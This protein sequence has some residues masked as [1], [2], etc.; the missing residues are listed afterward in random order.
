VFLCPL[1][2]PTPVH[3]VGFHTPFNH[4][5]ITQCDW[6]VQRRPAPLREHVQQT[7]A[8]AKPV[9]TSSAAAADDDTGSHAIVQHGGRG[10]D[11]CLTFEEEMNDLIS[12][13]KQTFIAMPAKAAGSSLKQLTKLKLCIASKV[14]GG[15]T[16]NDP[17]NI[18]AI[19][20]DSF[21]VP[22][23]LT[24][25]LHS[26]QPLV[27][28]IQRTSW[29]TSL[30]HVHRNE[31][32]R[33]QESAVKHVLAS[34]VHV[35]KFLG[36]KNAHCIFDEGPFVDWIPNLHDE[37]EKGMNKLMTCKMHCAIQQNAPNMVFAHHKQAGELHVL[38]T[39]H[40]CP[41]LKPQK[42][43]VRAEKRVEAFI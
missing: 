18:R 10:G 3:H 22:K 1:L 16:S 43:N 36:K 38:L 42:V 30:S 11:K 40:H 27:D 6:W 26:D 8:A 33:L 20:T 13:S 28:L 15:N 32:D 4:V 2:L 19:L 37:T 17:C 12:A 29:E 23:I 21:Q 39:K 35:G 5:S 25:H 24:S 7:G 34:R 31:R 9:V 14:L 41:K